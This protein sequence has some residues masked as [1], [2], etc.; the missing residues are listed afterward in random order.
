MQSASHA[1]AWLVT[2][3]AAFP[4][5][6][7]VCKRRRGKKQTRGGWGLKSAFQLGQNGGEVVKLVSSGGGGGVGVAVAVVQGRSRVK[8]I[9]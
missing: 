7:P 8:I 5:F 9:E 2:G 1:L 4:L 6:L 3:D